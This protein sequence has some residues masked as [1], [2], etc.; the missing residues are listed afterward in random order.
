LKAYKLLKQVECDN[1]FC[2][3]DIG[4]PKDKVLKSITEV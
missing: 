2:R 4:L 1:L 3:K